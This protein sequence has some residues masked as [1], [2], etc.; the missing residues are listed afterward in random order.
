MT[1]A[2]VSAV[3]CG[4]LVLA[5]SAIIAAPAQKYPGQP[6]DARVWIE[7]RTKPDAIAISVQ[8]AAPDA[9]LNVRVAAMPP[10]QIAGGVE[11]TR[12]RWEYRTLLVRPGQ[13]IA[14]ELNRAGADNW[15]A[16]GSQT[17][18]SSGIMFVM[19]RPR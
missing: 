12:Q 3:S 9:V 16:T 10:V 5:G 2:F 1:K 13:D 15:E 18:D 8:D 6:T 7:N 4:A 17:Q 19:K 14:A 11:R